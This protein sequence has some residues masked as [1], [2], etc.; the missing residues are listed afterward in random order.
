M[1]GGGRKIGNVDL[2][3][4][5]LEWIHER[6]ANMSVACGVSR[7]LIT[8]KAKAIIHDE[9]NEGDP[10]VEESCVA[11]RGWLEKFMKRNGLSLRR[12]TTVAQIGDVR[13]SNSQI[14]TKV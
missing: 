11:S 6:R 14:I 8:R 12:R 2:E 1:E 10:A 4:D 7:K 13:R 9:I 3:T 5:L